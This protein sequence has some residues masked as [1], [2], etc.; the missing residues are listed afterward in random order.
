MSAATEQS[1]ASG[2]RLAADELH[3]PLTLVVGPTAIGGGWKRF[4]RLT[5]MIATTDF[6]LTYFGSVLG[7]IWSFMQP[8]LFFGVLYVMF[9]VV[10]KG[11]LSAGAP[12]FPVMLLLN[13]VLFNFFAQSTSA[14]AASVVAR[15]SLV[16]K[17]SFPR[18]VIPVAVVCTAGIQL[19]LNLAVV[20]VF[21]FA[22]G[23]DP[24]W[25]WLLL[26]VLVLGFAVL[27]VGTAMILSALYVRYRDIAPI[28][29]VVSQALFYASPVFITIETV[30]AHPG[31][32][33]Y[34]LFNPLAT[35]L[36]QTRYWIIGG[37]PTHPVHSPAYYMGSSLWL[38]VPLGLTV[39]VF[40]LGYWIFTHEAPRIAEEL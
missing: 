40:A 5:F 33:R 39:G 2:P 27:S 26:P 21:M 15:E 14:A 4:W 31:F 22:Y 19:L 35:L 30:A 20:I 17:M 8:L 34:Y 12:Y 6:K 23:L 25:T 18:L 28:W 1:R 36:Q 24:R 37:T 29:S 7:Y 3:P 11:R 16:R 32:V 10:L 9:A 38:M 13:I